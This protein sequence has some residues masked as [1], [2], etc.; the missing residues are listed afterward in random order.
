MA[1]APTKSAVHP[2]GGIE[3]P[4]Q[5]ATVR[6]AVEQAW[7]RALPHVTVGPATQFFDAGGDSLAAVS[8]LD[9]LS[10]QLGRE[11]GLAA[12]FERPV[13]ADFCAALTAPAAAERQDSLFFTV[14]QVSGSH[15]LFSFGHAWRLEE[16]R[17][18]Y[19]FAGIYERIHEDDRVLTDDELAAI[20]ASVATEITRLQPQGPIHLS[21]FC[22]GGWLALGLAHWLTDHGRQVGY[23]GLIETLPRIEWTQQRHPLQRVLTGL[24]QGAQAA[25][26]A[27]LK[28]GF[29]LLADHRLGRLSTIAQRV[30]K[31]ADRVSSIDCYR[32]FERRLYERPLFAQRNDFR[33]QIFVRCSQLA[34]PGWRQRLDAWKLRLANACDVEEVEQADHL[35][36][37][38]LGNDPALVRRMSAGIARAEARIGVLS[39]KDR[40]RAEGSAQVSPP[41]GGRSE[42]VERMATNPQLSFLDIASG[43]RMDLHQLL[44]SA[45]LPSTGLKS[46]EQRT[47]AFVYCDG[48]VSALAALL[49]LWDRGHVTALFNAALADAKKHS[50]E[51]TYRPGLIFD[52]SRL[53]INSFEVPVAG[54]GT[55]YFACTN[56]Q[57]ESPALHPDLRVLLS[58]SGTTGDP[59]L[60]KLTARNLIANATAITEY[61]P[62]NAADVCPLN[63]P[64]EYSYGLSVLNA[65]GLRGG[66]IVCGTRGVADP[67]FWNDFR[68]AQMTSLA[69]TP[70]VYRMLIDLG[71]LKW[72]LPSLRYFTQAGGALDP[73]TVTRLA[74]RAAEVGQQFFVMYGQTE[75]TARMA[76]L[77]PAQLLNHPGSI[78]QAIPGGAFEIDADTGEL[79]YRGDN[80][81]A[82]YAE[83]RA[84]LAS[85]ESFPVLRT[86]DLARQDSSGLFYLIG[87]VKRIVKL[88][89]H[90]VNLDEIERLL[91]SAIPSVRFLCVGLPLERIGIAHSGKPIAAA[92][93]NA[94][95]AA[96]LP[97]RAGQFV[98]VAVDEVPLST[99]GKPD[100]QAVRELLLAAPQ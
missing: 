52:R 99:T 14:Q 26:M 50:L 19:S 15:A 66:T 68:S 25:L 44:A 80:I 10:Q 60:V 5:T 100:Y 70:D 83:Q 53:A 73:A 28:P 89:G 46:A 93:L 69:G 81:F 63:L 98:A 67:G 97:I 64:L 59:K 92:E 62:I 49:A 79:L 16:A 43:C 45:R 4:A 82:G 39:P 8:M 21:G 61:L 55:G 65:N 71:F 32:R 41:R 30:T 86:G 11:I 42:L 29:R 74:A 76:Y 3:D 91:G 35:A 9:E 85:I 95:L 48:S 1:S 51:K 88:F 94:V 24:R 57:F 34:E 78:G 87:R 33:L 17:S 47:L 37:R 22:H 40:I 27:I 77:P 38:M 13:F 75:A 12:I 58:T 7:A 36:M 2:S 56:N 6:L 72:Q 18:V 31:G 23:L 54:D 20:V 90:R 96:H 84:D